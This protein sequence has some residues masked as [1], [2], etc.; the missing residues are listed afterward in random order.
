MRL[1]HSRR[2]PINIINIILRHRRNR[3][4]FPLLLL[5][6]LIPGRSTSTSTSTST[7]AAAAAATEARVERLKGQARWW[8]GRRIAEGVLVLVVVVGGGVVAGGAGCGAGRAGD[9]GCAVVV[10]VWGEGRLPL[11]VFAVAA[12]ARDGFAR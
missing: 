12:A 4:L 10:A 8:A 2:S 7:A 9:G 1:P 6:V 11:A 3:H 5:F